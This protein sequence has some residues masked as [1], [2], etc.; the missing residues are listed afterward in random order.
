MNAALV[1]PVLLLGGYGSLGSRIARTLRQLHPQLP[2]AIAGRSREKAQALAS[3]LGNAEVVAVDLKRA[4]LG[5]AGGDHFSAVVMAV[6]DRSLNSLRYAQA[7]GIPYLALSDAPFELGPIVALHAHHARRNAVVLLGHAIGGVPTLAAM[8]YA[9]DFATVDAIDV[10]L[11][12][13]P[14]DPFG[15]MSAIDMEHIAKDGPPPLVLQRGLW[16]W[17]A[18]DESGRIISGVDGSR[19]RAEA[20]GLLDVL[21]LASIAP[22]GS[23]RVDAAQGGTR[24]KGLSQLPSHEIVIEISGRT[25]DGKDERRRYELIDYE[26]H[27]ALSAKGISVVIER[28]LGLNGG[29]APKPGLYFPQ[30]LIEPTQ[31]MARLEVWKRVAS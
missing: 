19:H 31:L 8:Y 26:G 11:I 1:R 27:A 9:R 14:D 22:H 2:L 10:G 18:A 28:V 29:A 25:R 20:V 30:S 17:G 5:L 16:R 3:A 13:D 24:R 6:R 15:P 12:F 7:A 4:D 23:L 21:S